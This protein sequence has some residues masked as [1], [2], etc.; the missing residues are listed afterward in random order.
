MDPEALGHDFVQVE[1]VSSLL[2]NSMSDVHV[3]WTVH[4]KP[5]TFANRLVWDPSFQ[6]ILCWAVC[7]SR[8]LRY[9]AISQYTNNSLE[10]TYR[11]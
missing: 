11:H 10:S 4:D 2:A 6:G 5:V 9:V 1:T 7:K 8:V 3:F